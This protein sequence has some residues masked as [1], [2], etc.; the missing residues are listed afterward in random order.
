MIPTGTVTQ[1]LRQLTDKGH[2][3]TITAQAKED[4][5]GEMGI[6]F[7]CNDAPNRF[8]INVRVNAIDADADQLFVDALE[9]LVRRA[10]EKSQ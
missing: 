4:E 6:Q 10:K 2:K 5:S 7:M 8:G 9:A 3:V 1:L